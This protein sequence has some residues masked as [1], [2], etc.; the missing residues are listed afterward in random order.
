MIAIVKIL[1]NY[2]RVPHQVAS[3]FKSVSGRKISKVH[4]GCI[5][6]RDANWISEAHKVFYLSIFP[7]GILILCR[8]ISNVYALLK[9]LMIFPKVT[10]VSQLEMLCENT[11]TL[12]KLPVWKVLEG[13]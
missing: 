9:P 3:D 1:D 8:L 4:I 13:S 10:S 5:L 12:N 7:A 11:S 6:S 2:S